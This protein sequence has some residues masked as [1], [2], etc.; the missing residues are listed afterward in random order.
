MGLDN[1]LPNWELRETHLPHQPFHIVDE[2]GEMVCTVFQSK[3]D[4]D[5]AVAIQ[6]L[7]R[8]KKLLEMVCDYSLAI[9]NDDV[10]PLD[11]KLFELA[12]NIHKNKF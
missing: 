10:Y 4:L 8:Y 5:Y 3:K 9:K 7:P 11:D 2:F 1:K 6:N 12:D